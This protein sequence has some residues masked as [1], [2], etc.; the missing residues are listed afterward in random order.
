MCRRHSRDGNGSRSG[1]LIRFLGVF[2]T[3]G[4]CLVRRPNPNPVDMVS[5]NVVIHRIFTVAMSLI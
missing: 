4:N 3:G 1:R 2:E 5:V